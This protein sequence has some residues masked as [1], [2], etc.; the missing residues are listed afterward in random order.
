[1]LKLG[2]N[3]EMVS[4]ARKAAFQITN[5]FTWLFEGYTTVATERTVL[6]L[7]GI[8]GAL[9]EKNSIGT[10][11]IREGLQLG[12]EKTNFVCGLLN[13]DLP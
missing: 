6:R 4:R 5:A 2:L 1:M 11:D 12:E 9:K 8:D 13:S 10:I 3:Q 7:M